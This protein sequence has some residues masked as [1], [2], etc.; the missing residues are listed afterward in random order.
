MFD[1]IKDLFYD[2]NTQ[3]GQN[4]QQ[5]PGVAD[6][7]QGLL[8][9]WKIIVGVLLVVMAFILFLVTRGMMPVTKPTPEVAVA[10]ATIRPTPITS[11]TPQPGVTPAPTPRPKPEKPSAIKDIVETLKR[12][13][14]DPKA[15][16][17][18]EFRNTALWVVLGLLLFFSALESVS[19][20]DFNDFVWILAAA[21]IFVS[22]KWP[23]LQTKEGAWAIT[24]VPLAIVF[25]LSLSGG[26]G[27]PDFSPLQDLLTTTSA[28]GRIYQSLGGL[29]LALGF[30][31]PGKWF[32][33]AQA[34]TFILKN[35]KLR[36]WT[37]FLSF[38]IIVIAWITILAEKKSKA[39]AVVLTAGV[40]LLTIPFLAVFNE[41]LKGTPVWLSVF[42]YLMLTFALFIGIG[43]LSRLKRAW[44]GLGINLLGFAVS[45]LFY[46]LGLH[47]LACFGGGLLIC[48]VLSSLAVGRGYLS[49]EA[50]R[51]IRFFRALTLPWETAKWFVTGMLTLLISVP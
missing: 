49:A 11:A 3:P 39:G 21:V 47:W 24:L 35:A 33:L 16:F 13:L 15:P 51:G 29:N 32:P 5:G 20:L 42:C 46:L 30:V 43:E 31:Q 23:L 45:F 8:S 4:Q 27:G 18:E 12:F 40:A 41:I 1:K 10:T 25:G 19:R 22:I 50:V 9:H 26:P 44:V 2:S 48:I 36:D 28:F 38:F 34:V 17:K 6:K 37:I 7:F 14:R